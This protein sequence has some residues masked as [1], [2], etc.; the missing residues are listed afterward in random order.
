MSSTNQLSCNLSPFLLLPLS[1]GISHVNATCLFATG[2]LTQLVA[3]WRCSYVKS[4]VFCSLI[5]SLLRHCLSLILCFKCIRIWLDWM[6][7]GGEFAFMQTATDLQFSPICRSQSLYY[8][9]QKECHCLLDPSRSEIDSRLTLSYCLLFYRC[10]SAPKSLW[11]IPTPVLV[12]EATVSEEWNCKFIAW[13][14]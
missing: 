7:V 9:K 14:Q 12:F 5:A 13:W 3:S 8:H 10:L 11:V 6:K 1:D 2:R 4:G